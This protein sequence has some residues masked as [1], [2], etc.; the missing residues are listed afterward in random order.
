MLMQIFLS[1][2]PAGSIFHPIL[3]DVLE[4]MGIV[5]SSTLKNI[6]LNVQTTGLVEYMRATD[7]FDHPIRITGHSLGGEI[8]LIT[9]AQ[10]NIPAISVSGKILL[11]VSQAT[12]LKKLQRLQRV[13]YTAPHSFCLLQVQTP[14]FLGKHMILNLI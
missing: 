12:N 10:T 1:V 13:Y 6:Q 7:G 5:E 4:A 8:A 11:A 3:D 9:G 2:L 14:T